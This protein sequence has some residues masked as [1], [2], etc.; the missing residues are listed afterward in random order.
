MEITIKEKLVS[1][2]QLKEKVR[3]LA[4]QI[5]VDAAGRQIVL[6][7]VLK[8][9][10]VFAADLMR[11]IK[12]SV[13]IDTVACSSYGTKTVSSG[14][15]QLKKDLDLDVQGKYVVVIEDIIDTGRTL[16]F[17]CDHMKLHQ[18]GVLKVCTLLDKPARREVKLDADYVGF[19]IPD[20]F[21]VGYGID[22][23]EEYRNLPYIGWV[24]TD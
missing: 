24:E 19:E 13:Q 9:S 11:E 1:E 5:E 2:S 7:V 16:H 6:V 14:R 21:V 3:E 10:M 18:P 8:G 12:G 22:C 23:A 15:V 20:Y 17:L 4:Q